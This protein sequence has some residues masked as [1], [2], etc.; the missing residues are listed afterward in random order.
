MGVLIY[1]YYAFLSVNNLKRVWVKALSS[2]INLGWYAIS[3]TVRKINIMA[4]CKV[5][6]W[7]K[8]NLVSELI[9]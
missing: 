6:N 5:D 2:A 8:V 3:E 9:K 4:I 1:F 7:K